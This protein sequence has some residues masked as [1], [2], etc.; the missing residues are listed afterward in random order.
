MLL[1]RLRWLPIDSSDV[2]SGVAQLLFSEVS[3]GDTSSRK[4]EKIEA[5]RQHPS[6]LVRSSAGQSLVTKDKKERE[7]FRETTSPLEPCMGEEKS[8]KSTSNAEVGKAD[9]IGPSNEA[10][11]ES[12]TCCR[13]PMPSTASPFT[14]VSRVSFVFFSSYVLGCD[15]DGRLVLLPFCV[16]NVV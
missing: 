16:F 15:S 4:K 8:K 6:G 1:C 10:R 3:S 5:P 7:I 12:A 9:R 11:F 14:C 2:H 13:A